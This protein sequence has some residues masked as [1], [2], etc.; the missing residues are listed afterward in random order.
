MFNELAEFKE[1]HFGSF[2]IF[3]WSSN[4]FDFLNLLLDFIALFEYTPLKI[5]Q[6]QIVKIRQKYVMPTS[7][8]LFPPNFALVVTKQS[9]VRKP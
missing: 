7:I 8:D 9:F 6:L 4:L 3:V 5:Q 1:R 2:F